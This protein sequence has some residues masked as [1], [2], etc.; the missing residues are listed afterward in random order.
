VAMDIMREEALKH[1]LCC[2][3]RTE[4]ERGKKT[5]QVD[6]RLLGFTESGMHLRAYVWAKNPSE[7]FD[8]KCDLN[9]S[10][11][12]R[13]DQAGVEFAIPQRTILIREQTPEQKI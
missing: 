7:G 10:I 6:V 2:D 4:D 9:R 12:Q 5:P 3:N 11:K 8:I 13:F 1:P